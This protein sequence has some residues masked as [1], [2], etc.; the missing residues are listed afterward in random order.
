MSN[1]RGLRLS[2]DLIAGPS[3]RQE[4]GAMGPRR[5]STPVPALPGRA[6][7]KTASDE[8]LRF[9]TFASG[10]TRKDQ[11]TLFGEVIALL[12]FVNRHTDLFHTVANGR[13][14]QDEKSAPNEQL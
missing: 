11:W 7:D 5:H 13:E 1:T 9:A 12:G 6:E 14:L 4:R 3:Y 2:T 8:D 10:H